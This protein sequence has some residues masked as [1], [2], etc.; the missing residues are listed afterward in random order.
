[1]AML[2]RDRLLDSPT[3]VLG[4]LRHPPEGRASCQEYQEQHN[5]N[6]NRPSHR[7]SPCPASPCEAEATFRSTS[8]RNDD[9][10]ELSFL[11]GPP[12][13]SPFLMRYPPAPPAPTKKRAQ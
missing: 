12:P 6:G 10:W 8:L 7:V 3:E 5:E 2:F 4:I 13:S 1:M 9:P 11:P